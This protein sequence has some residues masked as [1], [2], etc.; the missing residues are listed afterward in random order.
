MDLHPDFYPSDFIFS[1]YLNLI[2]NS[3]LDTPNLGDNIPIPHFSGKII[4]QLC[5]ETISALKKSPI[6]LHIDSNLI[7]LGDI[8]GNLPTL[9]RCL[10]IFGLPPQRKYLFLGNY[11]NFGEYSIEVI[12]LLFALKCHFPNDIF[13]LRGL[14]EHYPINIM[15]GLS[16][17]INEIYEDTHILDSIYK[18]FS[19][20]P[21]AALVKNTI[22]CTQLR[23]L[24][25][26]TLMN[27]ILTGRLP[28]PISPRDGF[29]GYT[30]S[31]DHL[32][33]PLL[34]TFL[35]KYPQ[36]STFVCGG[37]SDAGTFK[38][39]SK[40]KGFALS[41]CEADSIAAILLVENDSPPSPMSFNT[42]PIV[43]RT[44]AIFSDLCVRTLDFT[45]VSPLY[46]VTILP[47]RT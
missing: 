1:K 24:T 4:Q 9:I 35:Q 30:D 37:D 17:E 19:Y 33:E 25:D 38:N 20:L 39:V 12:T 14:N 43:N 47:K 13:L 15:N 28:F 11:I 42:P 44:S 41:M 16:D 18:V 45:D 40:G 22:L 32:T 2:L 7:I 34:N 6:L 5:Q 31:A 29:Q 36:Y 23:T 3:E 21:L 8:H 26:S 46:P 27:S 10:G